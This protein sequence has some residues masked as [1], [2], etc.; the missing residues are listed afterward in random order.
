MNRLVTCDHPELPDQP[1]TI[2]ESVVP[3]HRALGWV[4]REPGEEP[5][6]ELVGPP[7]DGSSVPTVVADAGP[8][9]AAPAADGP[10]AEEPA[11]AGAAAVQPAPDGAA[12]QPTT[13]TA[14]V[15]ATPEQTT[16]TGVAPAKSRKA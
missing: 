3:G 10:A 12:P 5:E 8:V 14:T 4:P 1:I 15:A 9:D 16:E 6:P 7:A 11:P 13:A 2:P